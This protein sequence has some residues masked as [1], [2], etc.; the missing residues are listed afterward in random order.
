MIRSGQGSFFVGARRLAIYDLGC[1]LCSSF[2]ICQRY[3][4]ARAA[5]VVQFFKFFVGEILDGGEFVLRALHRQHQFRQ[6]ELDRQR[7]AVLGVL[8]QEN[9]QERDDGGAGVDDQLPGV[10]VIEDRAQSR[11]TPGRPR[12]RQEC[13]RDARPMRGRVGEMEKCRRERSYGLPCAM[14]AIFSLLHRR[15]SPLKRHENNPDGQR[16][17]GFPC[18]IGRCRK[19]DKASLFQLRQ[20]LPDAPDRG[21]RVL[22]QARQPLHQLLHGVLVGGFQAAQFGPV[23]RHRDRR[24]GACAGGVGRDR[25]RLAAVAQIVDEDAL[26][27]FGFGGAR[28]VSVRLVRFHGLGDGSGECLGLLPRR[29]LDRQDDVQALAAGS[30]QEGLELDGC[31]P[32]AHVARGRNDIFPAGARVPDRDRTPAG[33]PVRDRRWWCRACGFRARRLAPR[34]SGRRDRRWK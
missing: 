12:L 1:F 9:H 15:V 4:A 18:S 23:D 17:G 5:F 11:P 30:L 10:A 13:R 33:R 24:A 8:D 7:V 16:A 22:A 29:R 6:F 31:K 3:L 28:D 26:V 19:A 34:R 20:S 32:F 14:V 27:A 2:Q 21:P 25:R